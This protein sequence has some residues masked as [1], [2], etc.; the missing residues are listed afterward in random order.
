MVLLTSIHPVT[1][2]TRNTKQYARRLKKT[3]HAEVL[4]IDGEAEIVIQSPAAYQKLL[5]AAELRK[6]C[7]SCEKVLRRRS[8]ERGGR[9]VKC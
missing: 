1:D 5:D 7:P 3:G 9:L 8:A 2:F 4:T 6:R